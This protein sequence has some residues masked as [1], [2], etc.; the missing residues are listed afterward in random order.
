MVPH[1][2][3]D[4]TDKDKFVCHLLVNYVYK[5]S[6]QCSSCVNC[7]EKSN[8]GAQRVCL[9]TKSK[10]NLFFVL[11]V[12]KWQNVERVVSEVYIP[13]EITIRPKCMLLHRVETMLLVRVTQPF[14]WPHKSF[15][16]QGRGFQTW[17][18]ATRWPIYQIR[19][20]YISMIIIR[21]M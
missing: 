21:H 11:N 19:A 9:K 6:D 17:Y 20:T 15:I 18:N 7:F 8:F 1:N 3:Q 13:M 4:I 12:F 16:Q 5:T 14:F 2:P 10:L